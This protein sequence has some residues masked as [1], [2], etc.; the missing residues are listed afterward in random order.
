MGEPGNASE[1]ERVVDGHGGFC[2]IWLMGEDGHPGELIR[3]LLA[4]AR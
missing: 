1:S 2:P 3:F 4:H